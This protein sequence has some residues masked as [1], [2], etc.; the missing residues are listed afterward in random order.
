VLSTRGRVVVACSPLDMKADFGARHS[1]RMVLVAGWIAE[2]GV[3]ATLCGSVP[4][5]RSSS[6]FPRA[7]EGL[8]RQIDNPDFIVFVTLRRM[9]R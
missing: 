2:G 5:R 4:F 6:L 9:S 1:L 7:L 3:S 8:L